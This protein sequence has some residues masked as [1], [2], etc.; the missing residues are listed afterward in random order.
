MTRNIKIFGIDL[1]VLSAKETMKQMITYLETDL[2][3]TVEI[4]TLSMIMKEKDNEDWRE[5]VQQFD[6]LI[7]V[8][9]TLFEA[10]E[11]LDRNIIKDIENKTF[12][13]MFFRYL[14]KNKK[15]IFLLAEDEAEL[16]KMKA[17]V[18]EYGHGLH[19]V[20]DAILTKESGLE[21]NV[22]NI[23]NGIE[24]DCI[25]SGLHV[26]YSEQFIIRNR[27]LLNARLW[28]GGMNFLYLK[29]N[30][31]PMGKIGEF[32]MKKIFHYQV[33]KEKN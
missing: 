8:D 13:R 29:K 19:V 24:P 14:Q 22:I 31:K 30:K 12:L 21:E 28:I 6:L 20:G 18:R 9:K 23:I 7:P 1:Q 2:I 15:T 11:E 17:S 4:I 26:P 25:V 32:L 5:E 3:S 33:E 16:E 10:S 27:A